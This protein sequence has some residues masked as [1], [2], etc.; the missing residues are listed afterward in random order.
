MLLLAPVLGV[1]ACAA[2]RPGE[3]SPVRSLEA[4]LS[5]LAAADYSAAR[6]HLDR[7]A[8]APGSGDAGRRALLLAALLQLDPR[9]Q[10]RDLGVAAE[11]A[12]ALEAHP[13]APPWFAMAGSLLEAAAGDL[14]DSRSRALRAEGEREAALQASS[15]AADSATARLNAVAADRDAARRRVTQLE[16]ALAEREKELREKTQELERIRRAIRG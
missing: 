5:A 1:A 12:A 15:V 9:N 6:V 11:R 13:G 7:A 8:L 10:K 16:Q 3:T 14:A 4:G 2:F